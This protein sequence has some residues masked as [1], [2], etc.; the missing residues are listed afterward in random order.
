[1]SKPEYKT[2]PVGD[3]VVRVTFKYHDG[4][5]GVVYAHEDDPH[6]QIV[7]TCHTHYEEL[8]PKAKAKATK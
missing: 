4:V 3:G 8:N 2:E 7:A 1:V 5:E 6:E